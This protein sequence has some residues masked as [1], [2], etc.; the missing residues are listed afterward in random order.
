MNFGPVNTF[1]LVHSVV[2]KPTGSALRWYGNYQ[3]VVTYVKLFS[4][5]NKIQNELVWYYCIILQQNLVSEELGL[6]RCML[7]CRCVIK[8]HIIVHRQFMAFISE[9][10]STCGKSCDTL[11]LIGLVEVRFC[12]SYYYYL[13]RLRDCD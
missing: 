13:E 12:I 8:S 4:C 6:W 9:H 10:E 2:T 3:V 11:K 5:P 1:F 7:W